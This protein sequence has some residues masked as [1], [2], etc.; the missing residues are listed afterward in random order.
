MSRK[1]VRGPEHNMHERA[2]VSPRFRVTPDAAGWGAANSPV[3]TGKRQA[4]WGLHGNRFL[5]GGG[6]H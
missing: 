6:E 4:G 3:Q 2:H 1:T 5:S